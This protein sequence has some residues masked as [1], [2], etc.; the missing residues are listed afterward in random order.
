[1]ALLFTFI[2][3]Y[4]PHLAYPYPIHIDE[5]HHI[6]EAIK[7]SQG[8]IAQGLAGSKIGFHLILAGL[9]TFANLVLIYPFLLQSGQHLLH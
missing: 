6:T 5:W 7:L 3:V 4:T 9:D 1:M 2:I 8:E